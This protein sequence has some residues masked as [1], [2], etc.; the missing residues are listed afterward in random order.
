MRKLGE[1]V[2]ILLW[3]LLGESSAALGLIEWQDGVERRRKLVLPVA[4][5][6]GGRGCLQL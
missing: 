6:L 3:T 5:A 2:V 4:V 1:G